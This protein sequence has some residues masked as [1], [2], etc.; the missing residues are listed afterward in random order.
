M[1]RLNRNGHARHSTLVFSVTSSPH[2]ANNMPIIETRDLRKQFGVGDVAVEVLRGVNLSID[3]GEFV[4]L[5]GPSGS[6]KSTL[7]SI[8]GG[9]EPPTSGD[10]MLEGVKHFES[11]RRSANIVASAAY[12]F[13]FPGL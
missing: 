2:L 10:V 13:Y 12:R 1:I 7:M 3:A 6:G 5:M 9:I 4:A 8:V 11:Y